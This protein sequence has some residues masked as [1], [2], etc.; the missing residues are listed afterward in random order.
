MK[1]RS[2]VFGITLCLTLGFLTACNQKPVVINNAIVYLVDE[3][4][5]NF[6]TISGQQW[7]IVLVGEYST[8]VCAVPRNGYAF[9]G[10]S[11]GLTELSRF[12]LSSEEFIEGPRVFYARFVAEH[13]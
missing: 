9:E 2:L 3:N 12:D 8:E 11:D 1:R 5:L 6:G 7:Q 13:E 10:W 4:C